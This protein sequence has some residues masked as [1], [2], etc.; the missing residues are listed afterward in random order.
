MGALMPIEHDQLQRLLREIR[1]GSSIGKAATQAGIP[2]EI[3]YRLQGDQGR[4]LSA[5][6]RERNK[7]YGIAT[8]TDATMANAD[9]GLSPVTRRK[10]R[11]LKS[12]RATEKSQSS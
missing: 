3:A 7:R 10:A 4:L 5:A 6:V 2:A 9:S 8:W 11:A 1:Q 12:T